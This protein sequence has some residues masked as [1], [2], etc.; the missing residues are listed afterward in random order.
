MISAE[1]LTLPGG[2]LTGFYIKGHAGFG[3]EGED[4]VCAAV[5]S[6]VYLVVNA[7]IEVLKVEPLVLQAEEG[8]MLFRAGLRDQPRCRDFLAALK[9]HLTG[10]EEQYPEY[11]TVNYS[12]EQ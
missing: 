7:I 3:E 12:E 9:L 5:S 1:F 4:I 11:L 6:A 8:E 2:Q 10:L